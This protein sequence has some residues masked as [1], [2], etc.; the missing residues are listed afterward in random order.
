M[1]YQ[2]KVAVLLLG[3][4]RSYNITYRN[5]EAYLLQPYN[6][7]LYICT[8]DKRFNTKY[9]SNIKE[10]Y[11]T[12]PQI[13]SIYGKYLRNLTIIPQDSFVEPFMRMKDK[14][15]KFEAE[16]DRLFT[17]QKLAMCAH[18]IFKGECAR[19]NRHYDFVVKMRPDILLNEKFNI[20]Q[21]MND[22]Q[23]IVP[24]NDS[25]GGFNDHI[26]YG[27]SKVMT[28]YLT[29]YKSF[30]DIDRIDNGRACDVS[31]IEAGLKKYLETDGIEIL[32]HPIKYTILRDV[33]PQKIIFT[34]NRNGQFFVK[35]Y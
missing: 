1:A 32:R 11:M 13:R 22:N 5:L 3:N 8:Y 19:N 26:A 4:M 20:N 35:K 23:I 30:N 31:I 24:S 29:Y 16:L 14:A 6:C 25:G 17:I 21:Y 28:K 12:E 9:G 34:G 2:Q 7:D 27:R 15:Y 10:E 18:D 33:K